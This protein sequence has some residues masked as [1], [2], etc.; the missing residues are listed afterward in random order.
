MSIRWHGGGVYLPTASTSTAASS[1]TD[2]MRACQVVVSPQSN[3]NPAI[4]YQIKYTP[5]KC[6]AL[7]GRKAM[8]K[9]RA[10][11]CFRKGLLERKR[12]TRISRS[13]LECDVRDIHYH[14]HHLDA[15]L[16]TQYSVLCN[17]W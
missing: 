12:W 7:P 14:V 3:S 15:Y 6:F 5:E 9:L 2:R 17:T 10:A 4:K 8:H 11:Y 16:E 1:A 13:A